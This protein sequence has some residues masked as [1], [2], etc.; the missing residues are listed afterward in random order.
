MNNNINNR[1]D[2]ILKYVVVGEPNVG[3]S[4]ML[5][6]YVYNEFNERSMDMT[7]GVDL[8]IKHLSLPMNI[9]DGERINVKLQIYDTAGQ[10]KF[11]EITK[12]Y[13]HN[14]CVIIV[15][16]DKTRRDTFRSIN[17]NYIKDIVK[18]DVELVLIGNKCDYDKDNY[19]VTYDEAY[20]FA[21]RNGMSYYETSAKTGNNVDDLFL[22]ITTVIMRKLYNGEIMAEKGNGIK[23]NNDNRNIRNTRNNKCD[24]I[25]M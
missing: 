15:V 8:Y 14:T 4:S 19:E 5:H 12:S 25:V 20:E 11:R 10:K 21:L 3:K 23:R 2:Y 17:M 16:F 9:E 22:C 1:Y 13:Y 7:I 6:R 18:E 24:C